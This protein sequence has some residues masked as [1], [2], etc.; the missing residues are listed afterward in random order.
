MGSTTKEIIELTERHGAH[1]YHPLPIVISEAQGVWVKDP[2][3]T[4]SLD[5]LSASP[6]I[7]HGHRPPEIVAALKARV[8]R[9]AVP[10]RAFHN[11]QL[12]PF[13]KEPSWSLWRAREVTAT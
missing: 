13:L 8:D 9:V 5:M 12:G 10:S 11:D 7:T 6:A 4:K 3:G 1:N 2:D